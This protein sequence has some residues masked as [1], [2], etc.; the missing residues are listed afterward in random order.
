MMKN[1]DLSDNNDSDQLFFCE[2]CCIMTSLFLSFLCAL[3]N[4][5]QLFFVIIICFF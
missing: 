4:N 5:S 3:A 1:D 2:I